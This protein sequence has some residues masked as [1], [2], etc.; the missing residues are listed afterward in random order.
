MNIVV[1]GGTGF[2]GRNLIP[3]LIK[4]HR[5][6][7]VSRNIN[8]LKSVFGSSVSYLDWR[9]FEQL[10]PDEIDVVIN[11]AGA[12]I[13]EKRWSTAQKLILKTSRV[14]ATKNVVNWALKSH[15]KKPHIYNASA[16]GIYG[17]Q[18]N[19]A[20]G[21]PS[22]LVESSSVTLAPT[23]SFLSD[24]AQAWEA[25]LQPAIEAGIPVTCLRFAVVLKYGEGILKKLTPSFAFGLG[26][27]LGDGKQ[28]FSWIHIEDLVSA[29]HF[30]LN[31][32]TVIGA[33]NLCSPQCITQKIFAEA[34]AQAMHRPLFLKIPTI[35]I[36]LL[37]GQMGE[38]LLLGGANVAPQR[39]VELGF[40]FKYSDLDSLK[41]YLNTATH[42][43]LK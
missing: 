11:L 2:V 18:K 21:L 5:I 23:D 19:Q 15:Q 35:I 43:N 10:S 40:K 14:Q 9:A 28:A 17:L 42:L 34:L 27:I 8:K 20:S 30:L 38:E 7:A 33:V 26:S 12:N 3:E 39:L 36:K 13:A 31:H 41:E 1:T 4:H 37:F 22:P 24:I 25:S 16:I 32:P 29:I 6:F